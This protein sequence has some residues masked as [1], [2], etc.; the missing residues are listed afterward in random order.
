MVPSWP[1]SC[2]RCVEN[3]H[4]LSSTR[5]LRFQQRRDRPTERWPC[6]SM[7]QVSAGM[8]LS[9][10]PTPDLA[11]VA[12]RLALAAE[13]ESLL[14]ARL[15]RYLCLSSK[16]TTT[17]ASHVSASMANCSSSSEAI[18]SRAS[19]LDCWTTPARVEWIEV[20]FYPFVASPLPPSSLLVTQDDRHR[21]SNSGSSNMPTYPSLRG[22][23]VG[24]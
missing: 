16:S 4:V 6:S 14:G 12:S 17:A 3:R 10:V 19:S 24:R 18:A 15:W 5:G 22:G 7:K 9:F 1:A 21:W 20:P 11:M 2:L 13:K 8:L 23:P